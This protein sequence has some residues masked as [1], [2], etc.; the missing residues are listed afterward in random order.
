MIID[1]MV[2]GYI[3][4]GSYLIAN[5]ILPMLGENKYSGGSSEDNRIVGYTELKDLRGRDGFVISRN[6]Q[7]NLESST[8]HVGLFGPTSSGKTTFLI[9]PNM[10]RLD[11]CSIVCTDPSKDIER[12]CKRPTY[13]TYRFNTTPKECQVGFDPL[14]NCNTTYDVRT[15]METLLI[16]GLKSSQ[17][18]PHSDLEK[19]AK[20]SQPLVNVFAIYNFK[21][22]R[23]KFGDMMLRLLNTP[24]VKYTET[25][26]DVEAP[27]GETVKKKVAILDPNCI[28]YEI[29]ATKDP[30]LI[31]EY[32]GFRQSVA[33]PEVMSNIK[34]TLSTGFNIFRDERI[35]SICNI[36]ALKYS[37]LREE[38]TILYIQISEFESTSMY[39][40]MAVMMQQIM[41]TSTCNPKGLPI[42]LVL[43]ELCNIGF[44][45]R[46]DKILS[47][48]RRYNVGVFACTQSITQLEDLYG[49]IRT[50][51]ILENFITK[52]AL[53]G[54]SYTANTF[55]ELLGPTKVDGNVVPVMTASDIRR[56]DRDEC[57]IVHRNR[58]GVVD[59]LS[60]Y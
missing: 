15:V 45:P 28:E 41:Y 21:Y 29:R 60:K 49:T 47:S 46:L 33:T 2:Y 27:N 7:F 18:S 36:P 38:K 58:R 42:M 3:A 37:K 39:P 25:Y 24:I 43:D 59:K 14:L 54:L 6:I 32:E 4:V 19:W 48:V 44:I 1:Y 13:K 35:R 40:I 31:T 56:L 16:N 50:K 53:S 55:T 22:K 52:I 34:F 8:E 11:N 12:D 5:A 20:L 57:L 30:D 26:V 10:R 9:K 17:D 51:T 23:Y